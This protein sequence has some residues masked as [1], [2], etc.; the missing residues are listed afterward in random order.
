M[1]LDGHATDVR[2]QLRD[3]ARP[4]CGRRAVGAARRARTAARPASLHRPAPRTAGHRT[5]HSLGP[6]AR[7]GGGGRGQSRDA[8]AAGGKPGLRADRPGPRA[9]ARALRTRALGFAAG[10]AR[11]SRAAQRG[12]PGRGARRHLPV[13]AGREPGAGGPAGA[14]CGGGARPSR[15]RRS[16]SVA[17][18]RDRRRRRRAEHRSGHTRRAALA[19]RLAGGGTVPRGGE[20]GRSTGWRWSNSWRRFALAAT[21]AAAA[22]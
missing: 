12:R 8:R 10:D 14:W 9:R 3:R 2:R 20:G 4:R 19:R 1:V 22:E 15:R 6:P 7:A 11:R 21:V 13:T 5:R 16:S 17:R 18:G